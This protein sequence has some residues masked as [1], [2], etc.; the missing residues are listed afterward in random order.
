[1]MNDWDDNG[2]DTL[3]PEPARIPQKS[4][5]NHEVRS[6]LHALLG[7]LDIFRDETEYNL[8]EQ[9][10]ETLNRIVFFANRLIDLVDDLLVLVKKQ[11]QTD[12]H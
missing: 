10:N 12:E 7:Y 11:V 9:Q 1:M 4:K 5:I 8:T 3:E 6:V 2:V